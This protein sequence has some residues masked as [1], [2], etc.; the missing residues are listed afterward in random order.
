MTSCD[1]IARQLMAPLQM[2]LAPPVPGLKTNFLLPLWHRCIEAGA[3]W[4]EYR[5]D[6]F[7]PRSRDDYAFLRWLIGTP[8][9]AKLVLAAAA[10]GGAPEALVALDRRVKVSRERPSR[11]GQWQHGIL[12]S[13]QGW[14]AALP[15]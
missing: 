9:R 14:F 1:R 8:D 10:V 11:G 7:S 4:P 13:R 3:T 12:R 2:G 5:P 6:L 15:L